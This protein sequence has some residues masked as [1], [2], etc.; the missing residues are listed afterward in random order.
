MLNNSVGGG[1]GRAR[2]NH[3][4]GLENPLPRCPRLHCHCEMALPLGDQIHGTIANVDLSGS[5][6]ASISFRA[7]FNQVMERIKLDCYGGQPFFTRN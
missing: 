2:G 5:T 4:G 7:I 3:G 6:Y 1:R